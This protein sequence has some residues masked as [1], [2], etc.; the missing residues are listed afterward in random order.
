MIIIF[1]NF[2]GTTDKTCGKK[3]VYSNRLR[4]CV[5][6]EKNEISAVY[7]KKINK[8]AVQYM[9][10]IHLWSDTW[11]VSD[12]RYC[13]FS[14][15]FFDL[16][17]NSLTI[18]VTENLRFFGQHFENVLNVDQ[19]GLAV[20][21]VCAVGLIELGDLGSNVCPRF[22]CLASVRVGRGFEAVNIIYGLSVSI[23]ILEQLLVIWARSDFLERTVT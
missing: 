6:R 9:K 8:T 22:Y 4:S 13:I 7:R 15:F 14:L 16:N 5:R 20:W 18:S 21:S 11:L 10:Y 12:Y 1:I 19:N 3:F 23:W 17:R 2:A